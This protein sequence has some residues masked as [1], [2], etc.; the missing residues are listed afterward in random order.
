MRRFECLLPI[1]GG[2]IW[3]AFV[4]GT[5]ALMAWLRGKP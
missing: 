1:L 3:G 2:L 4:F 5:I